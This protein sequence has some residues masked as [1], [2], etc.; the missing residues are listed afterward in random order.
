MDFYK[1]YKKIIIIILSIIFLMF[2]LKKQENFTINESIEWEKTLSDIFDN[3]T[4]N[5]LEIKKTL[6]IPSL[7][8]D[9]QKIDS[10]GIFNDGKKNLSFLGKDNN[11]ITLKT[12]GSI[13]A[14]NLC[15]GGICLEKKHLEV[16]NG[17][18]DLWIKSKKNNA[19]LRNFNYTHNHKANGEASR[20]PKHTH[21][22]LYNT[23]INNLGMFIGGRGNEEKFRF[24]L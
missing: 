22:D 13:I 10:N 20:G 24:R 3:V 8:T 12:D 5:T 17:N 21:G 11:S 19:Y 14:N 18:R 1:N 4:Y 15:I 7:F 6:S 9:N 2:L 16:L 23:T